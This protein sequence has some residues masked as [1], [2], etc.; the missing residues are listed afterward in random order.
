MSGRPLMLISIYNL[1]SAL[2]ANPF[3]TARR[4]KV[5]QAREIVTA[6][7]LLHSLRRFANTFCNL[8]RIMTVCS[9]TAHKQNL[10]WISTTV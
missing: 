7:Y 3:F 5:L 4:F 8:S 1:Y 2:P 6:K 9:K 10:L